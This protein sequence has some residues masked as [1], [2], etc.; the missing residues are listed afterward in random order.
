MKITK[1][2][3]EKVIAEEV[4]RFLQKEAR[5]W[6]K[7]MR[8]QALGQAY[9]D[10][11]AQK[12]A[13]EEG[14][15]ERARKQR[16]FRK[17]HAAQAASKKGLPDW[18]IEEEEELNEYESVVVTKNGYKGYGRY[19]VD[20][21]GNEKYLGPADGDGQDEYWGGTSGY[22]NAR[23]SYRR[24]RLPP[25]RR[26]QEGEREDGWGE[27]ASRREHLGDAVAQVLEDALSDFLEAYDLDPGVKNN[28]MLDVEEDLLDAAIAVSHA[29]GTHA[30]FSGD[31]M[32]QESKKN[33]KNK[34][35]K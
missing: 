3:L 13:D 25:R 32:M 31:E 19:L 16:D 33:K 4:E 15:D 29:L 10:Y 35:S 1:S 5:G 28:I 12:D 18:M 8:S 22:N 21:E 30:R 17:A 14:E 24:N 11:K 20:D 2:K 26:Y 6:A 9:K 7:D 23:R 27:T 34:K